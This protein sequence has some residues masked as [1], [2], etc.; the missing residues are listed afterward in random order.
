MSDVARL[1]RR[2]L[3]ALFGPLVGASLGAGCETP[4]GV[5]TPPCSD[6]S[7]CA[8]PDQAAA[9]A[10]TSD[11]ELECAKSIDWNDDGGPPAVELPPYGYGDLD[12][13]LTQKRRLAGA[14]SACCYP[15]T[16]PCVGG[17]PLLDAGAAVL[18]EVRAGAA[19]APIAGDDA[20][21]E[22][23]R[24]ALAAAW[25]EDA[26]AEHA[27][28]ASFARAAIELLPRPSP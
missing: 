8:R 11:R 1:R 6:G 9:F 16:Y 26:R 27:S 12:V 10:R 13:A 7:W 17:R 14:S 19:G 15:W 20:L 18:P 22:R 4:I 2:L 24:A 28:I 23:T 3:A 25:L 5:K 21:D